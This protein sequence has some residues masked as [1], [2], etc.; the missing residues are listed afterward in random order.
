MS[1]E[2]PTSK[3]HSKKVIEELSSKEE[4]VQKVR[5]PTDYQVFE[6]VKP[7]SEVGSRESRLEGSSWATQ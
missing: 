5:D 4:P 3:F 6:E 2:D 1:L 7:A